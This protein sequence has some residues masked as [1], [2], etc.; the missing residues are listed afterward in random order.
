MSRFRSLA[1][2][3]DFLNSRDQRRFGRH[4][5]ANSAVASD[6]FTTTASLKQWFVSHRLLVSAARVTPADLRRA[7]E[8]RDQIR[9]LIRARGRTSAHQHLV[10][11][12]ASIPVQLS[13]RPDGSPMLKASGTGV[14][15][16]LGELLIGSVTSVANGSWARLKMCAAPD[17]R[18]V[19]LDQSKNQ[20]GRWCSMRVCGNRLKT[21]RYR[22]RQ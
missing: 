18:W 21:R 20:L 17:C 22:R 13:I 19:F 10:A 3:R 4:A 12:L 8:L 11:L 1:L 14:E 2:L 9:E 16:A 7:R 5:V 15:R 6:T